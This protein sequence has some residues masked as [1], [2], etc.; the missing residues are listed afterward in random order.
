[1]GAKKDWWRSDWSGTSLGRDGDAR[2]EALVQ[3]QI[4]P[5]R[6]CRSRARSLVRRFDF[7]VSRIICVC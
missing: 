4:I 5:V 7:S 6:V 1:M 3:R 2:T